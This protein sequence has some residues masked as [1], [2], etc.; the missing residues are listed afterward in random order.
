MTDGSNIKSHP[1]TPSQLSVLSTHSEMY[2]NITPALE[3]I[4]SP[5]PGYQ[6]GGSPQEPQKESF[7]YKVCQTKKKTCLF[8]VDAR[9][10]SK[11]I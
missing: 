10:G 6:S 7:I 11:S 2:A 8:V 9:E 3:N 4:E 5:S 1:T